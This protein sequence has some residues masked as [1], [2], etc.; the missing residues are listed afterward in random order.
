MHN[1]QVGGWPLVRRCVEAMIPDAIFLAAL[2]AGLDRDPVGAFRR[3]LEVVKPH[4]L[5]A[6]VT[7]ALRFTAALTDGQ[8]L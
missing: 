5:E 3:T 2:G 6:G 1:G 7:A 4:M 8:T